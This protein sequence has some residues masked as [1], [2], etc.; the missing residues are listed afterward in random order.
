[1]GGVL[2]YLFSMEVLDCLG[3]MPLHTSS[4]LER[5]LQYKRSL[6]IRGKVQRHWA[7]CRR[8][9]ETLKQSAAFRVLYLHFGTVC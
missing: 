3:N 9:V 4:S 6:A 8:W 2:E 7:E 5:Y 1:M